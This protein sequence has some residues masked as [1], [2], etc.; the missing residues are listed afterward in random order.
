MLI[1]LS[2]GD[3]R[4]REVALLQLRGASP[5][6]TLVLT[7]IEA[8]LVGFCGAVLGVALAWLIATR[9]MGLQAG[10]SQLGCFA[11]AALCGILAALLVFAIP[12]VL[13]L[14]RTAAQNAQQA[15]TIYD[16]P[17]AWKRLWLDIAFLAIAGFVFWQSA[18]TG[19]NVV[20]APEGVATT[21]VDYKAYIAPV[22]LWI[23]A[24]LLLMRCWSFFMRYGRAALRFL[25]RPIAGAFTGVITAAMSREEGRIT[26]GVVLVALSVS[27]AV[28]TAI[29]NTTYE[30]QAIVDATLTNG[31]D[32]TVTGSLTVPASEAI[33]Q[34]RDMPG[35]AWAEP[36]QHR[37]TYVGND[38]QD[39]YGID[40]ETISK[41]SAMSNAYFGNGDANA[42]LAELRKHRDGVL[43]SD[44]T[45]SDF[46]LKLG[47]TLNLRLQSGQDHAYHVV[48]F[49]FIGVVREFPTAPRD[50]FLVANAAYIAEKT[51]IASAEVVLI[52][53]ILPPAD[54]AASMRAALPKGQGF[55]VSEIGE[56]AHRIGS[57]LVAVDLHNLTS[58]ELA[59][60]VPVVAG[61]LGLV[62]ALGVVER[63]RTFAILLAL[64]ASPRQLGAFLWSEALLVYVAGMAA[65]LGIGV[66]LAWVLV[67]LMTQVFDPPPE[68]LYVPWSYLGWL[69]LIGLIAVATSVLLQLRKPTE[70]LSFSIR[71]L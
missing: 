54:L 31:A 4:R 63:R 26:K 60:A 5:T 40:P 3:R 7:G 8:S 15:L 6:R 9:L 20:A 37:F 62:F 65:G 11:G 22:F 13:A 53:S 12:T 64:G 32:V 59:F 24:A 28:S 16:K 17:L 29:F 27:F 41:A 42:T 14:R 38:L 67:K 44:E 43:V 50:S 55:G 30:H 18:A 39:L 21:T 66:A 23:G 46:Q 2:G 49:T 33:T 35:V 45:V 52:K 61:A 10:T 36:M 48:P 56:A 47:D 51:G 1:V 71:N 19:Y 58:L 70:P 68:T 34:I 57:S 69:A 25:L